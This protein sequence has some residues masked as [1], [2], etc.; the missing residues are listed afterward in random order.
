MNSYH[1]K[2]MCPCCHNNFTCNYCVNCNMPSCISCSETF[3][4][5][6][7]TYIHICFT[8]V[9]D[10]NSKIM[11]FT[12][13]HEQ[14]VEFKYKQKLKRI[15]LKRLNMKMLLNKQKKYLKNSL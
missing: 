8:C 12:E 15:T 14:N 2:D 4:H 13:T 5:Y 9:N 11:K 1:L 6:D 7:N 3:I 10:I